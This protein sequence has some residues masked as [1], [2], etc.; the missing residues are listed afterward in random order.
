VKKAPLLTSRGFRQWRWLVAWCW[1]LGMSASAPVAAAAI[2]LGCFPFLAAIHFVAA[3][4]AATGPLV[5]IFRAGFALFALA[6]AGIVVANAA[7]CGLL[8]VLRGSIV[9]H[10][11]VA[12]FVGG[13][14]G[15][16]AAPL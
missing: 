14:F 2:L 11:G 6:A 3:L 7:G 5:A 8:R 12:L 1:L 4:A 15:A 16:T 13:P 9:V 10:A